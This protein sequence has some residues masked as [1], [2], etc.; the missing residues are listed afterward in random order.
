MALGLLALVALLLGVVL[1]KS[2]VGRLNALSAVI[3]GMYGDGDLT[4]AQRCRGK[5]K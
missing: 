5:T 1:E 4:G 3:A 2:L